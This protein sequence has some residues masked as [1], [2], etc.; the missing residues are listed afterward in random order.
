MARDG[1]IKTDRL[2]LRPLEEADAPSIRDLID[3]FEVV[4]W[5]ASVPHPYELADAKQFIA[6]QRTGSEQV[7]AIIHCTE[8]LGVVGCEKDFGYW[9]GRAHWGQGYGTEAARAVLEHHFFC[10]HAQPLTSAHHVDNARS[11]SILRNLGFSYRGS[12]R[13]RTN[14]A[15]NLE[16]ESRAMLLTPEQWHGLNPWVIETERLTIDPL[17]SR[18]AKDLA[19]I[20][21]RPDVA[22]MTGSIRPDW[23]EADAAAWIEQGR[24]RGKSG[25][26]MAIRLKDGTLIGKIGAGPVKDHDFGYLLAEEYWSKGYITEAARAFLS[27]YTARF[28]VHTLTASCFD[29]NPASA[30]VLKKLGFVKTDV[31]MAQSKARLEPAAVSHY[32]L[33]MQEKAGA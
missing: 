8:L 22:R 16:Y 30:R 12:P 9:L 17:T 11:A 28:D 32:R 1:K 13:M 15:L 19:T 7:W 2:T 25:M 29:D 4:R 6:K 31:G 21:S 27:A 20:T 24:W 18:D 14:A 3:D 5:L 33:D 23:T 10:A 26:R